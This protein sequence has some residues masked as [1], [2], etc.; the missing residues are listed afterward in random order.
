MKGCAA[1]AAILAVA[2]IL[3]GRVTCASEII[4]SLTMGPPP[5]PAETSFMD[6]IHEIE[7]GKRNIEP[8]VVGFL[9][10]S[11]NLFLVQN[12]RVRRSV[13]PFFVIFFNN[14]SSK[15]F[16]GGQIIG[17]AGRLF[18]TVQPIF[19]EDNNAGVL[20]AF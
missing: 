18:A 20:P 6:V 15:Q 14:P 8:K 2:G 9:C 1:F 16:F 7:I 17:S 5:P 10:Y 11:L 19:M 3:Y 12:D 4:N 13:D